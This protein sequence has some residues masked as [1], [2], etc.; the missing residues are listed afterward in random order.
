MLMLLT[1]LLSQQ[2][3]AQNIP[4]AYNFNIYNSGIPSNTIY[5][6][7]CDKDGN[8]WL[9]TNKGL[10]KYD[11]NSFKIFNLQNG[12]AD[13]EIVNLFY[14]PKLN[15][16]WALTYNS[17]L[18]RI[19]TL[20][21]KFI[22]TKPN[23]EVLGAFM[24]AFQQK[25]A[26][27]FLT[28]KQIFTYKDQTFFREDINDKTFK[29]YLLANQ[30]T[31]PEFNSKLHEEVVWD[32]VYKANGVLKLSWISTNTRFGNYH[33]ILLGTKAYI[34]KGG[35]IY[36]II[37]LKNTF[38]D[39]D[40][41]IVDLVIKNKDL[42]VAVNGKDGG[43]YYAKDYFSNPSQSI[44]ER[45]SNT[46]KTASICLDKLGNIWYALN[47]GLYV[48][49]QPQLGLKNN[50]FKNSDTLIN[51]DQKKYALI[52]LYAGITND[53]VLR[54]NND[55][56]NYSYYKSNVKEGS[57]SYLKKNQITSMVK[58]IS[59]DGKLLFYSEGIISQSEKG[60]EYT[61]LKTNNFK[62]YVTIRKGDYHQN[63]ILVSTSNDSLYVLDK[64]SK[65]ILNKYSINQMGTIYN[66]YYLNDKCILLCTQ[67][68]V[69]T[70]NIK[71]TA[72]QLLSKNI[73]KKVLIDNDIF[74]FISDSELSYYDRKNSKHITSLFNNKYFLS[75][76]T[77]EN[78]S[79]SK[80]KIELLTDI[81]YVTADKNII[82][83][84][85]SPIQFNLNSLDLKDTILYNITSKIDLTPLKSKQIK[86]NVHFLNPENNYYQKSYSFTKK[87]E[88]ENWVTFIG[89]TFSQNNLLPGNY[90]LTI[91]GRFAEA[92]TEKTIV[93]EI[94]IQPKF[95]Q[96]GW[97]LSFCIFIA[98]GL[99]MGATWYV[100]NI[101]QKKKTI[102]IE[103]ER[104]MAEIE[105]KAFLNQLNPHFLYNTLNTLQ[106]YIIQ[107]DTHN[108]IIY[109]QRVASLHRN[110]L[111]FNQKDL[112]TV[113][114]EKAFLEK[115][116]FIQQ[117]RYSDKFSFEISFEEEIGGLKLPPMLLQPL[118]ENAIEHGFANSD[119]GNHVRV[120][121]VKD[122]FLKITITDNG[123]GDLQTLKQLKDGHALYMIKE[124]LDFINQKKNTNQNTINFNANLPKGI[125]I[126][127]LID[128]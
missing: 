106:D 119:E 31:I 117:K 57:K 4:L 92:N 41:F 89:N 87:N 50:P 77:I 13:N 81:G 121:F 43:I 128:I 72:L 116:L 84:K 108:G 5:N 80:D 28:P 99:V 71:L 97:F 68:G 17:Q 33:S 2:L 48:I 105:N 9:A 75:G 125:I 63:K 19:N 14:Q 67:K 94:N 123:N 59:H 100:F 52:F 44:F 10:A 20:N 95:W 104:R 25:K 111:E 73:Y 45:I 110:I 86:F 122:K 37:N 46:S 76:F 93:Y 78:I 24:Y 21:N 91:K 26:I 36:C 109:L 70:T 42:Y 7:L 83:K 64:T 62:R 53:I 47:S 65:K 101:Q 27:N 30:T 6:I 61:V 96:T 54:N 23:L 118:V 38:K 126:T 124:R 8:L 115:Y 88:A 12:F 74:Y 15:M 107:K 40:A 85:P 51:A 34:Q 18:V 58:D 127:I 49:N 120:N 56:K 32:K 98:I 112:I 79:I 103:L 102:K 82:Y 39:K 113:E 3:I 29:N 11:G 66:I 114:D 60:L 16:L 22:N 35:K 1:C 90:V 55:N 69:Y